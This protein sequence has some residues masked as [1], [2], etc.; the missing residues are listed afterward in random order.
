[1][2][3]ELRLV[4]STFP[5][6]E[7]AERIAIELV[8]AKLAACANIL[9]Q[10]HSVYRWNGKVETADETLV[11]FKLAATGY[12]EFE[13]KLKSLHPYDVPEIIAIAVANGLPA[14]LQWAVENSR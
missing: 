14:Y 10:V 6:R 7:T 1:M 3:E 5:D 2:S 4:F 9:P 13:A 12:S 11:I 8:T